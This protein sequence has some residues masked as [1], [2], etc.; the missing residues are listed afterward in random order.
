MSCLPFKLEKSA[1]QTKS[2]PSEA[3]SKRFGHKSQT[4]AR[5]HTHTDT[6]TR[7]GKHKEKPYSDP[8]KSSK[9]RHAGTTVNLVLLGMAGTGKSAS[10]NTILGQKLFVSRPSSKPVTKKCQMEETEKEGVHLCVIDTPDIFD[11]DMKS[12][13]RDKHVQ[14]CKQLY[15]SGPFVFVLVMHVSRFTDGERDIL[16]KLEKAFGREVRGRTIILFTRG[17]DLQQAGLGLEDFLH[18]CQPDLKKILEK[19]GN[20]CVLFENHRSD[21]AQV[22]KLMDNVIRVTEEKQK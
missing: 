6:A 1:K 16:E 2:R 10:G 21:S 17:D 4:T 19:C 3:T 9:R 18:T 20:R 11:D 15:E 7:G 12:S 5:L 13:V 8:K 14:R 22:E